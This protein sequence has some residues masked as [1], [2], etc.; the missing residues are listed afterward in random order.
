VYKG[1]RYGCTLE[2]YLSFIAMFTAISSAAVMLLAL[3][4]P[5]LAQFPATP[6]GRK[7]LE[8]RF[9]EGVTITYK[10]VGGMC[11]I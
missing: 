8:S 2:T 10:E 9:G 5:V 11:S 6:E 4:E 7:V 3:A 1:R